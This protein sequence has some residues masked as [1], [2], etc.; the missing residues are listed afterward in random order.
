MAEAIETESRAGE[1]GS[2]ERRVAKV[3]AD[4]LLTVADQRGEAEEIGRELRA[5][6]SDVY[7][8]SPEVEAALSSPVVR[9]SAKVPVLEH[10][11]KNNVSD[12]LFN[13]LVVLNGKERLSLLR[14]VAAAYRDLLDERAKRVRVTVRSAV[15]LTDAQTERLKQTISQATGLEPIIHPKVDDSLLGGMVIQ[16]GD[17]VF[18]SSV[19]YQ[20]ESIRNQL[21]ARSSYEIQTGRDRFSSY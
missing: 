5:I 4:A 18:D 15:P 9:R 21:L 17:R 6:V 19:R 3:Y 1:E 13:F 16:V 10:A 2:S 12:L 14:H 20:I 7:A 8:K 11:F